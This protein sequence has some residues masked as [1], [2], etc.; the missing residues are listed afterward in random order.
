MEKWVL[1]SPNVSQAHQLQMI[2]LPCEP[3]PKI[4]EASLG[5]GLEFLPDKAP[6]EF[7]G[8]SSCMHDEQWLIAKARVASMACRICTIL[9][10]HCAMQPENYPFRLRFDRAN[11]A[12]R[13]AAYFGSGSAKIARPFQNIQ[14]ARP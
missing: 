11:H 13:S 5:I 4:A 10:E 7:N 1:Q 6:Q 12:R 8:A 3:I 2:A 9:L 14:L